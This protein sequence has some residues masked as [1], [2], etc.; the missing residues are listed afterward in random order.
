MFNIQTNSNTY[1]KA[2]FLQQNHGDTD[3]PGIIFN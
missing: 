1:G 2:V 3:I